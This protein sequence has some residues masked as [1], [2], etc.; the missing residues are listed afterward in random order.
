M[1][2][3]QGGQ[4]SKMPHRRWLENFRKAGSEQAIEVLW[5]LLAES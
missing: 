2:E 4:N 1:A 3:W 5:W